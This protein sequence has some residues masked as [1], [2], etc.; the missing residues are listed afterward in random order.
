M[1]TSEPDPIMRSPAIFKIDAL[2]AAGQPKIAASV[3]VDMLSA[4]IARFAAST[5]MNIPQGT[6]YEKTMSVLDRASKACGNPSLAARLA[7]CSNLVN[8]ARSNVSPMVTMI[9]TELLYKAVVATLPVVESPG[10]AKLVKLNA[11]MHAA[12]TG[13]SL[14]A[15][16]S[17]DVSRR[18][19]TLPRERLM[20]PVLSGALFCGVTGAWSI[21]GALSSLSIQTSVLGLAWLL[22][23]LVMFKIRAAGRV[24][25]AMDRWHEPEFIGRETLAI[26]ACSL[27][28]VLLPL[29]SSTWYSFSHGVPVELGT[30][31]SMATLL[32]DP[33]LDSWLLAVKACTI[34]I[35]ILVVIL[36]VLAHGKKLHHYII[37]RAVLVGIAV[38]AWIAIIAWQ[39]ESSAWYPA[40]TWSDGAIT[41]TTS[42]GLAWYA[43]GILGV[44]AA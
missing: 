30:T 40:S 20:D 8:V 15:L 10:L 25:R 6:V 21:L 28:A 11:A 29:E 34:G 35:V 5:G 4:A 24:K 38:V 18:P 33:S 19:V 2:L 36:A 23:S 31:T 27:L 22:L 9:G 17:S 41:M 3:M 39:R 13:E 12:R 32:V 44:L 43:I 14:L 7:I 26:V 42:I 16:P 37:A 1:P